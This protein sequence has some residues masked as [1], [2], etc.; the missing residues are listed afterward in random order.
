MGWHGF[1]RDHAHEF[2]PTQPELALARPALPFFRHQ[3]ETLAIVMLCENDEIKREA[4][5]VAWPM[6]AEVDWSLVADARDWECLD[7]GY[8]RGVESGVFPTDN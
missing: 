5:K 4:A 3:T 8:W 6:L 7:L 2:P 1:L